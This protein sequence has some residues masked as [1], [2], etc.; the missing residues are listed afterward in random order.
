MKKYIYTGAVAAVL[1]GIV[2]LQQW[3]IGAVKKDRD[4]CRQNTH[5]LLSDIE[6]YRTADSLQAVS[7][8]ELSL[9]VDE[10][11]KYRKNGMKLIEKLKAGCSRQYPHRRK[12]LTPLRGLSGTVSG[13]RFRAALR[14]GIRCRTRRLSRAILIPGLR[15]RSL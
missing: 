8:G 11:R 2:C 10:Y 3:Q 4:T 12:R 15:G 5:T 6:R 14:A 7:T 13:I 9:T 1:T